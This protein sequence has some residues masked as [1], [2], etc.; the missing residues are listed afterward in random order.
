MRKGYLQPLRVLT[1]LLLFMQTLPFACGQTGSSSITGTVRDA[2]LKVCI[3]NATVTAVNEETG[4]AATAASNGDGIYEI[5]FLAA[6]HYTVRAEMPGFAKVVRRGVRLGPRQKARVDFSLEPASGG[7]E[8]VMDSDGILAAVAGS[9]IGESI[10]RE[11]VRNLPLLGRDFAGLQVLAGGVQPAS[12][13]G[14]FAGRELSEGFRISG[15][16]MYSGIFSVEQAD[17][18]RTYYFGNAASPSLEIVQEVR[19]LAAGISADMGGGASYVDLSLRGGGKSAH[20]SVFEYLQHDRLSAGNAMSGAAPP[21]LRRNQFGAAV[22]GPLKRDK[23]FVFGVYEGLRERGGRTTLTQVATLEQRNGLFPLTGAGA[24]IIKDPA[25]NMPFPGNQI[26]ESRISPLARYFLER[27]WPLPNLGTDMYRA[28]SVPLVSFGQ[29]DTK[30]DYIHGA[31]DTFSLRVSRTKR[32]FSEQIEQSLVSPRTDRFDHLSAAVRY[33]R[34][35]GPRMV[36]SLLV[37]ARRDDNTARSRAELVRGPSFA[38]GIGLVL[39]GPAGRG[40]PLISISGRGFAGQTGQSNTPVE[41]SGTVYQIQNSLRWIKGRQGFSLGFEVKR[42]HTDEMEDVASTGRISFNGRYSGSGLADFLLGLPNQFSYTPALGRL[43]LRNT[44]WAAFVQ[45]DWKIRDDLTLNLGIRYEYL[46]WPVERHDRMG[47]S[48]PHLGMRVIVASSNGLLPERMDPVAVASYPAGTFIASREAGL[49]RSLRFPDRNN[50]GPR[51]GFAY[52]IAGDTVI[53]GSYGIAFLKESQA[54]FA[55]RDACFGLPFRISRTVVNPNPLTFNILRPFEG[56]SPRLRSTIDSALYLDPRAAMAYVQTWSLAV[57]RPVPFGSALR[58]GYVGNRMVHGRQSWDWNQSLTWPNWNDR[59]PGYTEITALTNGGDSRYNSLQ[60][61]FRK[62]A[63]GG[64]L[65]RVS[66]TWSKTLTNIVDEGKPVSIWVHDPSMQWGRSPWDRK[67]VLTAGFVYRLPFG[68]GSRW[69]HSLPRFLDAILGRWQASGVVKVMSGKPLTI[70]SSLARANLSV[71]GIVPADR[72]ADGRLPHPNSGRWFD[73]T[74]FATPP[75]DR[76]GNAGY[77]VLDGPGVVTEDLALYRSFGIREG[78][79]M[80]FR[81]EAY[82]AF[83]HVNLG[84]PVTDVD[85]WNFLGKI[86]TSG[87]A[88]RL[89]AALRLDF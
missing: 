35:V 89:Q 54:V 67:H 72:L 45:Q 17:N 26:P 38:D 73:Q 71:R 50:F 43:Y 77:G 56:F 63:T 12:S 14:S 52:R 25:T 76:P 87:P 78:A 51:V 1:A 29:V 58:I 2:S 30:L 86:L 62:E 33:T 69:L 80:Q 57:E 34:I 10:V 83:N 46:S 64:L 11:E 88:F 49:P 5:P 70:T 13:V 47:T 59:F 16:T 4:I 3:S 48:H 85:N 20:G 21:H 44:L 31:N 66:Y 53:R 28:E 39:G 7:E 84:D 41:H 9:D 79:K 19:I 6:G 55:D 24:V 36:N 61:E 68:N 42:F 37:A 65:G 74:A 8:L 23:L 27:V 22:S 15:G 40:Y 82:N 32:A 18:N 60:V 75:A 81:L